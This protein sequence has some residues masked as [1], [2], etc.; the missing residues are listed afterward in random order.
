MKESP[1]CTKLSQ[2]WRKCYWPGMHGCRYGHTY[3]HWW[4]D[5]WQQQD[6]LWSVQKYCISSCRTEHLETHFTAARQWAQT[7]CQRSQRVPHSQKL[8]NSNW[9]KVSHP[10]TLN[11]IE[12]DLNI[13]WREQKVKKAP[14]T[15]WNSGYAEARKNIAVEDAHC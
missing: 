7:Y 15:S 4:F 10:I 12:C 13:L 6:E 11:L 3:L 1:G 2:T 14:E 8:V 5:C 9:P